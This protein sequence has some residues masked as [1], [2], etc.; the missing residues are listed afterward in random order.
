MCIVNADDVYVVRCAVSELKLFEMM[1]PLS[2]I[3]VFVSAEARHSIE[4]ESLLNR[5]F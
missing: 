2:V 1:H 3:L 5:C 4:I